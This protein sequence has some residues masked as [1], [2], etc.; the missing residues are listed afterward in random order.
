[1]AIN[2]VFLPGESHAQRSLAGYSPWGHKELDMIDLTKHA[3]HIRL[4]QL[5]GK[6]GSSAEQP[7]PFYKVAGGDILAEGGRGGAH[8]IM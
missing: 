8:P 5:P 6:L 3:H 1:M 7:L 2:P 4:H